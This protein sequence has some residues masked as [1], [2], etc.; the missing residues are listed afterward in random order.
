[1]LGRWN[2]IDEQLT[3][4]IPA[5][6]R[7]GDNYFHTG[8]VKI[9]AILKSYSLLTLFVT[10]TF[11][12][13][14]EQFQEILRRKA[15]DHALPTNHPWE[16]VEYYYE[17]IYQLWKHLWGNSTMSGFGKLLEWVRRYEFQLRQAIHS[18]M[19][20]WTEKSIAELIE[21]RY[22]RAEIPDPI[23]EPELHSLVIAH[24]IH[25]CYPH[26]CGRSMSDPENPPCR[27]PRTRPVG[28]D[29]HNQFRC[30]PCR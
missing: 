19:L 10:V 1:M 23:L 26:L 5:F 3:S 24:Q 4:T 11:S 29:S 14:W 30:A 12:E 8:E 9:N 20:F 17:C 2:I 15:G 16:G 27:I 28:K 18:H 13:T 21:E 22:I 25:T 6:V 7:T